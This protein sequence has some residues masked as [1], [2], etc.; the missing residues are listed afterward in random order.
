MCALTHARLDQ[1][2]IKAAPDNYTNQVA[3]AVATSLLTFL[4]GVLFYR[5]RKQG[6][7]MHGMTIVRLDAASLWPQASALTVTIQLQYC[8]GD[9]TFDRSFQFLVYEQ[10]GSTRL[11]WENCT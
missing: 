10:Q 3:A 8:C 5:P 6:D 11:R 7:D 2:S 9:T 4:L 1:A